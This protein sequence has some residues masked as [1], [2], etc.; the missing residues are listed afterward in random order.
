MDNCLQEFIF[1]FTKTKH[2]NTSNSK[3]VLRL[4][5]GIRLE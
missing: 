2:K 4:I 5:A 1:L 3:L